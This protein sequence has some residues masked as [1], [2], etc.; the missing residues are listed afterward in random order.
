VQDFTSTLA[1][2]AE[3][4]TGLFANIANVFVSTGPDDIGLISTAAG[5]SPGLNVSQF[6]LVL[7]GLLLVVFLIFEPLGLFGIWVKIRN[8]WKG[9]PFT[10]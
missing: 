6:N 10:Y 8:Y 3:K 2:T 4:G 5:T 7:Y 9:W 1:D